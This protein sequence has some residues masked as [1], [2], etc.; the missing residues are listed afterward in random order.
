MQESLWDTTRRN[1]GQKEQLVHWPKEPW[2]L[3]RGI[4][5]ASSSS[6]FNQRILEFLFSFS[7]FFFFL[8]NH[9]LSLSLSLSLNSTYFSRFRCL[10]FILFYSDSMSGSPLLLPMFWKEKKKVKQIMRKLGGNFLHQWNSFWR[11]CLFQ[12][13]HLIGNPKP[14]A[15]RSS[16][17]KTS[18]SS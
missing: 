6:F 12:V 16:R 13:N 4:M 3:S 17:S 8:Y 15:W 18:S 2:S 14:I 1:Q 9:S 7:L 11:V 5:L 10:I